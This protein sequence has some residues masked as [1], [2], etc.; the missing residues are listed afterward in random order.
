MARQSDIAVL[1]DSVVPEALTRTGSSQPADDDAL[2]LERERAYRALARQDLALRALVARYGRPDPYHWALLDNAVGGDAFSELALH[3]V[4]QQLSTAAALTIYSRIR[5]LLGEKVEP[6][7]VIETPVQGFREAGL[8]GAKARSLQDLA[9]RI[10]DGR[11]DL[12][13]LAEAGDATVETELTAVLGIGPWSAQ[14]FLLHYYR[15]PD[16]MPAADIGLLRSAQSAF[17][18]AERPSADE[19]GKRAQR[20]RPYRSYGAALLWAHGAEGSGTS[21]KGE[22]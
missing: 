14:M 11:L 3:I 10:G 17:G 16:V 7:R 12:A 8:S 1:A 13:A 15:R 18:L 21:R 20:W 4:S 6:G 2:G 19:L 22:A 9:R 5:A